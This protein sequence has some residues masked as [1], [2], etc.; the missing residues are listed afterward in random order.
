[1]RWP[2]EARAWLNKIS[3]LEV[4]MADELDHEAMMAAFAE[5]LRRDDW[6]QVRFAPVAVDLILGGRASLLDE[7]ADLADAAIEI[8]QKGEGDAAL[9]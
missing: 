3:E 4:E 9:T 1:M 6:K 2:A 8:M 7:M 5:Q